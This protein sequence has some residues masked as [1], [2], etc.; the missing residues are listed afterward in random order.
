[1]LLRE[2]HIHHENKFHYFMFMFTSTGAQW[3]LHDHVV[4]ETK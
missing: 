2:L 3:L 1:M 4:D